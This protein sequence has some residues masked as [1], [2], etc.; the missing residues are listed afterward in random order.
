MSDDETRDFEVHARG[1]HY[2]HEPKVLTAMTD[3]IS[4]SSGHTGER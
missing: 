1:Y 3:H 4:A 2:G